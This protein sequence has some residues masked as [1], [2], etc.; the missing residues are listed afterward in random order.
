MKK[1]QKRLNSITKTL[2]SNEVWLYGRE[3]TSFYSMRKTVKK[4]GL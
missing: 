3:I 2:L 1:Q 4:E